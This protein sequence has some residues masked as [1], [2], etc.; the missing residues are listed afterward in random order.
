MD[1]TNG[2]TP[3]NRALQNTNAASRKA[4]T[5]ADLKGLTTMVESLQA[6]ADQDRRFRQSLVEV[7]A[8]YKSPLARVDLSAMQT[9]AKILSAQINLAELNQIVRSPIFDSA[10][11]ASLSLG[12]MFNETTLAQMQS[13]LDQANSASAVWRQQ[14]AA[15]NQSLASL[16]NFNLVMQAHLADITKFAAISQAS[17]A[18]LRWDR[19]GDL[20]AVQDSIRTRLQSTFAGFAES[21]SALYQSFEQHPSTVVALPPSISRLPAVEFFTGT[22]WVESITDR[23][24]EDQDVSE[25]RIHTLQ[26]TK[27][28]S[29]DRL[30]ELLVLLNPELVILWRGAQAS[31]T[32]ANPDH[33][34][35]F[36]TSLRELF[37][38]VLHTLAPDD[39][40]RAWSSLPEYYDHNK[41]TRKAR[42]NYIF[43]TL[44]QEPLSGF[45]E[46]D[47]TALLEFLQVFQRGT[48]EI[49][50]QYTDEQ[51]Q[52][53]L[54][55][56]EAAIRYLLEVWSVS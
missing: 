47:V 9:A 3:T 42:L 18:Q 56:M 12:R 20:L 44:N 6:Y 19:I 40:V 26:T 32:S 27:E 24:Q 54:V 35:H 23:T 36:A 14:L 15:V 4:L 13:L 34:R 28:E 5:P 16:P 8:F 43:R 52:I 25:V 7:A 1:E 55:R 11:A 39:K 50:P 21:Y 46:K 29:R 22:A 49:R 37:T 2:D 48:H 45:I 31:L 17:L 10:N 51:L 30:E 33:V 41:P 38:H 53:M